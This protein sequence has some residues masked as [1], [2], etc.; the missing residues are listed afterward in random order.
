MKAKITSEDGRFVYLS[1]VLDADLVIDEF[2]PRFDAEWINPVN[3]VLR[4]PRWFPARTF[5][6]VTHESFPPKYQECPHCGK[7]FPL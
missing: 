2:G 5:V 6:E 7:E 4:A 1:A 3:R